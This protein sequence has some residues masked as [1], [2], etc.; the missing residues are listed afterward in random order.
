MINKIIQIKIIEQQM[1]LK[2]LTLNLHSIVQIHNIVQ[3]QRIIS[4]NQIQHKFNLNTRK[5]IICQHLHSH[6]Y[7]IFFGVLDAGVGMKL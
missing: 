6:L 5:Y 3:K 4:H 7:F 1:A 2:S